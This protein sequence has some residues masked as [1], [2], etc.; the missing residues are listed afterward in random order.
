MYSRRW[1]DD[2]GED[3][4]VRVALEHPLTEASIPLA[5]HPHM[6]K[7]PAM[8]STS[9]TNN[10]AGNLS[11][12]GGPSNQQES[13]L[14]KFRKSFS[15]RFHKKGSKESQEGDGPVED[16]DVAHLDD[17]DF[18]P[19]PA[20]EQPPHK[21][22]PVNDQKFRFVALSYIFPTRFHTN[23]HTTKTYKPH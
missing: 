16:N 13:V 19:A 18:P 23:L 20:P 6:S 2:E 17:E 15:L 14:Q 5:S 8:S 4:T 3:E 11:L 21:E 10:V 1:S 9:V 12:R 7:A 22:D